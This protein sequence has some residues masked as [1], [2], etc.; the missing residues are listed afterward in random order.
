VIIIS[1]Q[2]RDYLNVP[3]TGPIQVS[4]PAGFQLG[5]VV[6]ALEAL[7]NAL[8]PGWRQLAPTAPAPPAA[9]AE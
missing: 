8:A 2:G 6:R 3:L 7:F 4:R 1:A 9:P 5:E